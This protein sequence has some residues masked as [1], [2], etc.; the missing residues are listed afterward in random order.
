MT[1]KEVLIATLLAYA[2]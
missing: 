2:V 1:H